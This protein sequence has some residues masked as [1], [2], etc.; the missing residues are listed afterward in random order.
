MRLVFSF[1]GLGAWCTLKDEKCGHHSVPSHQRQVLSRLS[2]LYRVYECS[3]YDWMCV[4]VCMCVQII[5]T[6]KSDS[7]SLRF[8]TRSRL[9]YS[10]LAANRTRNTYHIFCGIRSPSVN[11]KRTAAVIHSR[12][13]SSIDM[14]PT[15][16]VES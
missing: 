15:T 8:E 16:S 3:V 7:T 2:S 13:K 11:L 4:C 14:P 12:Q 9:V 5:V 10:H 1:V 6:V